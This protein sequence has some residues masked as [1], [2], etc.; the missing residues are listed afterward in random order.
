[1]T[2]QEQYERAVAVVCLAAESSNLLSDAFDFAVSRALE[3]IRSTRVVV[4]SPDMGNRIHFAVGSLNGTSPPQG[5]SGVTAKAQAVGRAGTIYASLAEGQPP[6]PCVVVP[7]ADY[8]RL[9][10]ERARCVEIV[11]KHA[12]IDFDY[13]AIIR[14]IEEEAP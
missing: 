5:G 7:V 1:M 4:V 2:K 10:S 12:T 6:E 3:T 11:R 9:T 14:E 8:S 13:C